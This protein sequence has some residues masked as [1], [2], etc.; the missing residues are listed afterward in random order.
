MSTLGS[1]GG[2]LGA[3]AGGG[4]V[5]W[6]VVPPGCGGALGPGVSAGGACGVPVGVGL[7]DCVGVGLNE[8]VGVGLNEPVGVGN[9]VG[10]GPLGL[11]GSVAIGARWVASG[12]P[13]VGPMLAAAFCFHVSWRLSGATQTAS[14]SKAS[15]Q[16]Y[17]DLHVLGPYAPFG[18]RRLAALAFSCAIS[19]ATCLVTHTGS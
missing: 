11:V 15:R 16:T 14:P 4:E 19:A 9:E 10:T 8:P 6:V 5:N 1:Q 18:S 3:V 2:G 17:P 7:N 13:P 12:I